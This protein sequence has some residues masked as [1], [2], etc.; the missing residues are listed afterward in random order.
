MSKKFIHG[1]II[2]IASAAVALC[3]HFAGWLDGLEAMTWDKRVTI[4]A[5]MAKPVAST[6]QIR[7]IFIDQA[8]LDWTKDQGLGWPWPR[9]VYAPIL[10]FCK[11]GNAKV[12]IFDMLYTE[13]SVFG[14]EDDQEF[15]RAIK[16]SKSFIPAFFPSHEE[17]SATSWPENIPA[18]KLQVAGLEKY[19]TDP[20]KSALILPKCTFPI[21]EVATNSTM[22]GSA[23]AAP[24][25]KSTIIRRAMPFQV[26]D[27]HFIPSLGLAGFIAANPDIPLS[28]DKHFFKAGNHTI[29][30]DSKGKTILRYRG[31]SQT[32]KTV[33]ASAVIQSELRLQEGT[34]E[35]TVIDPS[36]FNDCYVFLGVSAPGLMDL[37]PTPVDKRYPGVEIHATILDN[38]LASHF[39][40]DVPFKT[41]MILTILLAIAAGVLGRHCSNGWQTVLLF[42]ILIPLPFVPAFL[43]YTKGYWMLVAVET[44][45]VALA[46]VGTVIINYA[47][48]GRQKRFIKSAFGQYISPL[49]IDKLVKHPESLQL[50]GEDRELSIYFSDIQGFT[51]ISESLNPT[52]LT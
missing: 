16:D 45:A 23:Y 39:Q 10:N 33:N 49:V 27:G 51:T 13:P 44:T 7:L 35:K 47:L 32:H 19:L 17:G 9:A 28:I 6:D 38:L 5:K 8:S 21:E 4:I 50:G 42:A 46:L 26:F 22:L 12:V 31:P 24:Q 36:F 14:V 40:K 29:P 3:L 1:I 34:E 25:H 41:I 2:G 48:E 43:L 15:G 11:R 20:K 52:E 37:K 30:L 18:K